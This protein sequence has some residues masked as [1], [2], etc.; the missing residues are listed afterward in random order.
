[1]KAPRPAPDN[2]VRGNELLP[3]I[4]HCC[5]VGAPEDLV[6][7]PWESAIDDDSYRAVLLQTGDHRIEVGNCVDLACLHR[8]DGA[9]TAAHADEGRITR[10]KPGPGH[11]VE[12]KEMA[13]RA[14]RG[15]PDLQALEIMM[16]IR[17]PALL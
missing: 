3:G 12:H 7:D 9:F 4:E 1:M 13:G 15:D 10:R 8:V 6:I 16:A 2:R 17:G 5:R 14:R 11:Q